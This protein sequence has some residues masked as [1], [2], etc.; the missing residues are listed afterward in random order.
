M[1][2]R[3]FLFRAGTLCLAV[4]FYCVEKIVSVDEI[5]PVDNNV[6]LYHNQKY[7]HVQLPLDEPLSESSPFL[8]LKEGDHGL[9]ALQIT[10]ALGIERIEAD[11]LHVLPP[12]IFPE[13]PPIFTQCFSTTEH[14]VFSLDIERLQASYPPEDQQDVH[15]TGTR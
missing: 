11:A 7:R 5:Q 14:L 6:L 13:R 10:E 4:P 9:I 1:A 12:Y 2:H 15:R 3:V 8:L